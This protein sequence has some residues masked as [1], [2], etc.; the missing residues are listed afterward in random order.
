MTFD[1]RQNDYD[2]IETDF[3]LG[4]RGRPQNDFCPLKF[5]KNNIKNNRSN[6]LLF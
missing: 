5:S 1:H 4:G 2:L 6:S 3:L